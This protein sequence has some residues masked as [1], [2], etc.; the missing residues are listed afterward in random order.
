MKHKVAD[1]H[2]DTVESVLEQLGLAGAEVR[3]AVPNWAESLVRFLT[4]P[5]TSSLLMTLGML[6]IF[7]EI[8]TP[9]L[10]LPGIVGVVCLAL[11]FWGQWLVQLAGWEEVL[12]VVGGLVLLAFEMFIPGFGVAGVLG[13]VAVL[14]GLSLSATG[15]GATWE[16]VVK[17]V[18][19]TLF[20]L[21]AA[22]VT[23]LLLL[24]ILPR[25]PFGRRLILETGLPAGEG[26]A[27][28]PESDRRWLGKRGTAASRLR[29]AGIAHLDGERVDVVS[30]GEFIEAGEAIEVIRV[31][32]NRI[33]V[34]R[35]IPPEE[36]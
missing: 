25:T 23:S 14:A 1:F 4:H 17:A 27:S 16:F 15:A 20:S 13:I 8:R 3:R 30:D 10:G 26:F 12:L 35:A 36:E 19:R 9:G 22:V 29:P 24:R 6:G 5:I 18:G 11:F 21:L 34:R 28:A 31:D 2:A 32:G 7:V 33:V